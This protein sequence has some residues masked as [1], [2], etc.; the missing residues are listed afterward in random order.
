LHAFVTHSASTPAILKHVPSPSCEHNRHPTTYDISPPNPPNPMNQRRPAPPSDHPAGPHRAKQIQQLAAD[1]SGLRHDRHSTA[2]PLSHATPGQYSWC[3]LA[4]NVRPV[5]SIHH[6]AS[7]HAAK[8]DLSWRPH[9]PNQT[10]LAAAPARRLQH[11]HPAAPCAFL[12]A[13]RPSDISEAAPVNS[14]NRRGPRYR[15]P[16]RHSN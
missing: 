6:R 4:C 13:P 14:R 10:A 12:P 9:F 2:Q 7:A 16:R 11:P 3:D 5:P 1:C 15:I 8:M